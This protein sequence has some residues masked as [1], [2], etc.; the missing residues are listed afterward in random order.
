[1]QNAVVITAN[2]TA[3][4]IPNNV[5]TVV[6][7]HGCAQTHY[8]RDT[9]W[10]TRKNRAICRAQRRM[11]DQPNRTFVAVARWT[12][13]EFSR[14]YDVPSAVVI[15]AWVEP[16][17]RKSVARGR[18]IVLGDWRNTN[19]GRD[20]I[21]K[22]A[23]AMPKVEFRQLKCTYDTR[24]ARYAEASCYLCL[25][26][27]EGG[28]LAVSDAEAAGLPIVTT[29]V[30]NVREYSASYVI[31]WQERADVATVTAA[32]NRALSGP[33]GPSFFDTWTEDRWRGAWQELIDRVG[34]TPLES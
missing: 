20:V 32:I 19:K 24:A 16:I 11:Y 23:A 3:L 5:R 9:D 27:S 21:P 14:H 33:R 31:S 18:P 28:S 34:S 2:E 29:D 15:P 4:L 6:V 30:G 17:P 26:L 12:A 25:S 8:E 10:Q 13:D 22:L 1:M 7:H